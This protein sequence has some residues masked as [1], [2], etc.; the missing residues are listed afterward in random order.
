MKQQQ[1]NFETV[2]ESYISRRGFCKA[3]GMTGASWMSTACS[4]FNSRSTAPSSLGFNEVSH[5]IDE[6][7]EVA[8]GY[9][10]QVLLRWG[11]PLFEDSPVFDPFSQTAQS[12]QRQFGYN[13]DFVGFLPLPLGST[14]SDHGLL[15]INHEYTTPGLMFP[16]SPREQD[17]SLAQM[18]ADIAAHGLSVVEIQ[19]QGAIWSVNHRSRYNRRITPNTAFEMRGPAAGHSRLISLVS[20]DG[21]HTLGT[22]ANCAGGV[23]PWGTVLSG[24]ENVDGHF[25][26]DPAATPEAE[27]YK[28]FGAELAYKHWGSKIARWNLDE[29]PSELLHA[30][31]IV[32]IDP[33]DPLSTPK[34]RTALGRFKHEGANVHV[35]IDGRVVAYSGDD[36]QFEYI[37]K[38]VSEKRFQP[39]NRQANLDLLDSG[40]LF[41]ARFND[42]GS[43]DWL[44]LVYGQGPLIEANGFNSQGDVCLDT[45]KAADLVGATA[46][47]RPEDVQTNP[48]TGHVFAMLTNNSSRKTHQLN[49]ANPRAYN[50]YG[51]ILEFWPD[52]N[53]HTNTRFTWD[54]FLLAGNPDETVTSYHPATSKY[55]WLSCPDNCA[56][57]RLGN[58]WITTDGAQYSDVADGI[59]VTETQ[60]KHRALTKRFLRIPQGA[61]VCGPFFTP[62]DENFF[63]AIQHPAEGSSF[64]QPT[65]RWPDFSAH[66]PPRPS[67]IVIR[68]HGGG[69]VG[70]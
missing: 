18:Q 66:M 42:D 49:A 60:G 1:K 61:E 44:P 52:N 51:Q 4:P 67:V 59:W 25:S 8:P 53:D 28:R 35:N 26:G 9:Q 33:Y 21:I 43:L 37:Y 20:S 10:T 70:S 45:R 15:V 3:A 41:A 39:D 36:A 12:Q 27:N 14:N 57:D 63:C 6:H 68:K 5:R 22:Y 31:W 50:G 64:D 7:L 40:T 24:E 34:K 19:R 54:L 30:G 38:F 17:L 65:T 32:E 62:N 46:M 55:G 2:L 16:G 13:C 29:N 48:V 56:F 47:D 23:T 11:D 58:L 69:R